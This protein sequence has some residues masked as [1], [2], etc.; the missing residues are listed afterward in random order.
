MIRDVI[1]A[2]V[3]NALLTV[4]YISGPV[5]LVAVA[6]GFTIG[7]LQAVTQIQDQTL[8]QA[9]KLLTV[10]LLIITFGA[11]MAQLV[12]QQAT[13]LFTDFPKMTR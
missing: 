3:N 2:S 4:L 1:F 10:L 8:P 13:V 6:I 5:L 12:S 9:V 11:V 7:L